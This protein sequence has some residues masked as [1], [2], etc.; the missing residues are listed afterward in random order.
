MNFSE[1]IEEVV[2]ITKRPDK[3]TEIA[4]QLNKALA[5]YTLKAN[6]AQDL[7][8]VSLAIDS[9]EYGQ[10]IDLAD[11]EDVVRFRKFKFIRPL[12]QRYYLKPIDPEHVLTP[13]GQIQKDRYYVAGNIVTFT[14]SAL[15]TSLEVGYY[16]YAP[17]LTEAEDNNTHW[18]LDKMPW[19]I[20]ERA[21][22]QIF[23]MIGDD[24]SSRFYDASS[25]EFFLAARRDF[26]DSVAD[27][28][29]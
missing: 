7:V 13:G 17:I 28:A 26:A 10:S 23:K 4:S 8:E 6:F 12:A 21:A 1:A 22:A 24:A 5:F 11:F 9:E 25:N 14:L 2:G 16:Q 19:A 27:S 20:T 15:D 3:E 18:M 29:S